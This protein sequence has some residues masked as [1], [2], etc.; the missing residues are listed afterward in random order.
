[1]TVKRGIGLK[2]PLKFL[3]V[4]SIRQLKAYVKHHERRFDINAI[5][6]VLSWP[7]TPSRV[8]KP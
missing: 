4:L 3:P 2:K 8:R 5:G 6:Q 7:V 1:M